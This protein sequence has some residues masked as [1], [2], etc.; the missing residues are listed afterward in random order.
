MRPTLE[1]VVLGCGSSGGVPRADGAWGA[2]DPSDRRN[3]R[4]RCSLLVRR[5]CDATAGQQTTLVVDAS[6]EMRLQTAAA[7]VKRLDALLLTHEHADQ[8]HGIDD[9]RAFAT[10]Q[11]SR[12]PCWMD[13]LTANVMRR[14]FAYIFQGAGAYPAIADAH[15]IPA[16]GGRWAI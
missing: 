4:T 5:L 11:G 10:T 16:H 8:C 12:I 6:P 13:D 3:W 9:I 7:G 15:L 1:V 2:C 14:R